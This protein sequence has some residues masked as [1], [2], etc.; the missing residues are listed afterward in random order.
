M[1]AGLSGRKQKGDGSK[2]YLALNEDLKSGSFRPVYLLYGSEDYLKRSYKKQFL[3]A[4]GGE[5]GMNYQCFE[6][7]PPVQELISILE[8][9]PFFADH[10]LVVVDDSGLFKGKA[11]EE[12]CDYIPHIPETSH[13]F[14]LENEIDKRGKLYKA[15]QKNGF[16]CELG[17]QDE[18]SLQKWAVRILAGAGKKIRPSAMRRLLAM[19]GHGMDNLLSE[20]E[21]LISYT[22]SRE[23]VEDEDVETICTQNPE[24]RV[25]DML[26]ALGRGNREAV[27]RYYADLLLLEV[28]PMKM[29][30]LLR[31]NFNQLLV[32]KECL[33]RRKSREEC[34]KALGLPPWAAGK[35]MEEARNYSMKSLREYIRLCLEYDEAIKNGNLKDRMAVELL[36]TMKV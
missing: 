2:D 23:A 12:L 33:E 14:F 20:L 24:D 31:R 10:R 34:G 5:D 17:E 21:K 28:A 16:V 19:A 15:V 6:G 35:R 3:K 8:T 32:A 11:P 36:L 30:A 7:E 25:F 4:I 18:A 9:M 26:S 22:G 13:L 1:A 27:M 29:L